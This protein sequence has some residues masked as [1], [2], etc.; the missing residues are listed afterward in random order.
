MMAWFVLK[1]SNTFLPKCTWCRS[2]VPTTQVD[3]N[4][5]QM[6]EVTTQNNEN[7]FTQIIFADSTNIK[8]KTFVVKGA[9]TLLMKMKN[10]VEE[11]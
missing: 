3:K 8:D 1:A 6:E 7:G 4:K 2:K 10:T 9:Y 5:F 11:E